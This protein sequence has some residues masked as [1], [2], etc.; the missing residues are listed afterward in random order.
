[1]TPLEGATLAAAVIAACELA[2]AASILGWRRARRR[3]VGRDKVLLRRMGRVAAPLSGALAS[4]LG[5]DEGS[6]FRATSSRSGLSL[7]IERRYPLL[8]FRRA[9]PRAVAAGF[10]AAAAGWFTIWFLKIP[11]GTWTLPIAG[12]AG[13]GGIWYALGWM[14]ARQETEF[15]R[16]FPEIVDQVVRLAGAGVPSMEA[17]SVVSQDAPKPVEPILRS[18][19]DGL[20]A[21]L[22]PDVALRTATDR[23]RLAEFTMFAAVIRL[24]RRS[25]GGV[26]AAF[27]NLS[28]TLRE[29]RQTAMKAHASTAQSRITLLFLTVMPVLVLLAQRSVAP[30]TVAVLFGTEGGATLLRWGV[31]LIAA[32]LLVAR[33][34]VQRSTR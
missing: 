10:G 22:D 26:S 16:I 2:V 20:L 14:Q 25:G 28:N 15:I 24:Q 29:R 12:L 7:F 27:A 3:L 33:A 32:G 19:C 18:V 4:A 13:A 31:G 11:A 30:E 34:L 17:L 21:G 9:L 23:V 6:I 5:S 1:M 8:E